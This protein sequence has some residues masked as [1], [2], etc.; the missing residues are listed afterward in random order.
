M[1]THLE[2]LEEELKNIWRTYAGRG[3]IKG[4]HTEIQ[5]E[6]KAFV[7]DSLNPEIANILA[8]VYLAKT[9][10]EDIKNGKIEIKDEAVVIKNKNKKPLAIIRSQK[11][12]RELKGRFGL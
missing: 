9:T 12:V 2:K 7:G 11:A 10:I 8:S 1:K 6:P 4:A 5:L 3:P